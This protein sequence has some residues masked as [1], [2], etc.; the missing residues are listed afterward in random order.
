MKEYPQMFELIHLLLF[1]IFHLYQKLFQRL[2]LFV[3]LILLLL[4]K[5]LTLLLHHAL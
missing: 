2:Q 4:Q 1:Q 3:L 5:S